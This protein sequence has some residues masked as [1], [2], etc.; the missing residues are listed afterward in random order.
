MPRSIIAI[1]GALVIGSLLALASLQLNFPTGWIGALVLVAWTMWA[2]RRWAKLEKTTGLEPSAPERNVRFYAIG[3]ALLFGHQV[4]TLAYPD[5][6]FHVGQG[7]YLAIDSWTILAAMIGVS[8]VVSKAGSN[9]DER[10]E[11]I[12]ARGTKAGF[13]S[14]IAGLVVFSFVMGFL[15]PIQGKSLTLFMAAN[16]QIAIIVASLLI[17]YVVQ[18]IEYARDTDANNAI[19]PVE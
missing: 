17:K 6:D 4:V 14:L 2:W 3:T 18:L 9:R 10:D 16:I 8:F 13:V 1:C 15:P 19:G 11:T 5:I 7:T 12:I